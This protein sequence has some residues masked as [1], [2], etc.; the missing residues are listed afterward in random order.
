MNTVAVVIALALLVTVA[1]GLGYNSNN[2]YPEIFRELKK[3]ILAFHITLIFRRIYMYIYNVYILVL[4]YPFIA[5]SLPK[6]L[7]IYIYY[8]EFKVLNKAYYD[9]CYKGI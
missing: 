4:S 9:F 2:I 5:K 3:M 7:K 8:L 1:S 6:F